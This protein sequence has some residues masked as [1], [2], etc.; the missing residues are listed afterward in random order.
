[1]PVIVA[2]H[3]LQSNVWIGGFGFMRWD[4]SLEGLSLSGHFENLVFVIGKLFLI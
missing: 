3:R 1:M 4:D 2:T